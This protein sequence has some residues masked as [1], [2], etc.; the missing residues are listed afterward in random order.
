VPDDSRHSVLLKF[1][2]RYWDWAEAQVE[3][4]GMPVVLSDDTVELVIPGPGDKA[5]NFANPLSWYPFKGNT[6]KLGFKDLK[7]KNTGVS[8]IFCCAREHAFSTRP[9]RN[10]CITNSGHVPYVMLRSI[11][12][13]RPVTQIS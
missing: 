4:V 5:Y 9:C 8:N 7:D 6:G 13:K 3:Q 1:C 12:R 11:P 2:S 10:G